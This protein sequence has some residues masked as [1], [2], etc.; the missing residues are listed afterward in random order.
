MNLDVD[1][2][3]GLELPADQ[4][5]RLVS[6]RRPAN[7]RA[8][9]APQPEPNAPPSP[10]TTPEPATRPAPVTA[11]EA[12]AAL[13]APSRPAERRWSPITV[14]VL[15]GVSAVLALAYAVS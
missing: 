9:S 4:R 6:L 2:L 12:Q 11:N 13:R 15:L 7:Q 1:T 14:A 3:D 8:T 10:E 5:A